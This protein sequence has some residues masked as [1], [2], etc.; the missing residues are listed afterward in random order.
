MASKENPRVTQLTLFDLGLDAPAA[1][2]LR[3]RRKPPAKKAEA[4]VVDQVRHVDRIEIIPPANQPKQPDPFECESYKLYLQLSKD[5]RGLTVKTATATAVVVALVMFDAQIEKT[6]LRFFELRAINRSFVVG[7][8]G[9]ITVA[10][11][12]YTLF[13][14][15]YAMKKKHDCGVFYQRVLHFS[16]NPLIRLISQLGT[17]FYVGLVVGAIVLTLIL[18]KPQMIDLI[19][20]IL[21]NFQKMLI[22]PWRTE[23]LPP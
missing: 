6:I 11:A 14:A 12:V 3:K 8:V 1:P 18:A 15:A 9:W 5:V 10:F 4:V 23:V 16:S 17:A 7:V 21:R 20:F 19:W 2:P 22:G 13:H